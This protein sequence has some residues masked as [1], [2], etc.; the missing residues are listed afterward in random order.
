MAPRNRNSLER[1]ASSDSTYSR[2]ELAREFPDDAACLDWLWRFIYSED[3][4]HAVCPKCGVVRKF[5]RV[6]KR[7]SYSCDVC[8]HHIHPT[9]GTIFEKSSTSLALWF[10]AI[11]LMSS[12]RCGI[13]AKQL[14]REIGVT[15]KTA[16]RMFKQIRTLLQEDEIQPPLDGKVEIDETYI[17][18]RR[19]IGQG[20][21]RGRPSGTSHYVPVF[22][23]VERKGRVA[24]MVV[25]N[26]KSETLMPHVTKRVLPSA[27]VFTDELHIYTAAIPKA[28]YAHRRIHHAQKVYVVGDIHT[29]SVEGFFSLL[30]RGI[31]GVYHSVSAKYLQ[32][33]LDEYTFRYNHRDDDRPMFRTLLENVVSRPSALAS[34]TP[35]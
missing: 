20:G 34:A 1:S 35:S 22:G 19:R 16:W 8:G 7:A 10:H 11:Y 14:E 9:T 3:G 31:A 28:G 6:A 4:S 15:Y 33:Y 17:G 5:H 26:V 29:N 23:M 12:T 2:D 24:A 30:K 27:T 13:S 25:P 21:K 32:S 18:G